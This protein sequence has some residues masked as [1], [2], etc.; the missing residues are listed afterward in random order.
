MPILDDF[1]LAVLEKVK[2]LEQEREKKGKAPNIVLIGE[3]YAAYT[4][5]NRGQVGD[6][7]NRLAMQR[8]VHIGR[9][10]N[11]LYVKSV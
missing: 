4:E 3:L 5:R 6:A 2:S 9:T 11:G 8:F 1:D 7:L 10:L